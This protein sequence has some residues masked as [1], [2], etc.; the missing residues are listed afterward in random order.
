MTAPDGFPMDAL[1]HQSCVGRS[2]VG[3]FGVHAHPGAF[4]A[5][6]PTTGRPGV[7]SVAYTVPCSAALCSAVLDLAAR[8]NV[9]VA[10][11]A[12][13][14]LLLTD[15]A[16]RVPDPGAPEGEEASFLELRLQPGLDDP[17]IRRALAT[18]LAL[19]D[20]AAWRLVAEAEVAR[21]ETAVEKL[22]YRNKAL[23][24][25]L[26][27]VSFQP[28]D[29]KLTQVRD[30]ASLFGFVNEWCFDED[31]VVRRFRELAP[32]YHPDTGVVG[33][34][35]RMAQLIEARNLLIRHVRT[36]YSSGAWVNRRPG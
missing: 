19:A 29:G 26:E 11:L 18:A 21:L 30:A 23:S 10:E 7:H 3:R 20:P 1:D 17:T 6:T 28:L 34:R 36:A 9:G 5:A 22:D 16:L 15:P 25:A 12:G 33:C 13:S 14:V 2:G 24:N 27:R 35:E 32:V 31:R 4:P 8:R